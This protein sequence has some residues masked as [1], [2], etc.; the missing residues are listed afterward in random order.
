[1]NAV[2]SN[3]DVIV[4]GSGFGGSLMATILAKQ[5]MSVAIVD[6][7]VHPRF[8]IGESSTPSGNLILGD[9]ARR[10]DL[11]EL[12]PLTHFGSW[13]HTYPDLL[14]GC[15]RGFSYFWHGDPTGFH[16]SNEHQHELLVAANLSR[17]VADTQWYRPQVDQFFANN[18]RKHGVD[19][20]E[21]TKIQ[22]IE[23]PSTNLWVIR[24][25]SQGKPLTFEAPFL[26]DA[27]GKA[28]VL[29]RQLDLTDLTS[30][31]E[32][33]SSAIYGHFIG[34]PPFEETLQAQGARLSDYPFP[35]DDS[36]IH[37]LFRDGWSFQL[38]F[39]DG[40][41]SFG[42]I[43]VANDR[44]SLGLASETSLLHNRPSLTQVLGNS[45]L[46]PLPGRLYHIDR[47]Q[48]LWESAAGCDWAALPF[49]T[50]FIDALH[51]TG[52]AHNLSGIERLAEILLNA[53]GK[54]R[55]DALRQYSRQIVRELQLIDLLVAGCYA[56]LA[57]FRLF[58]AWSMLYFAA[59]TSYE[60][61]R[62]AHSSEEVSYL[63]AGDDSFDS[64]ISTHYQLLIRLVESNRL[65]DTAIENFRQQLKSAIAP[66]NHVGLFEPAISNMYTYTAAPS[67]SA[68]QP[69]PSRQRSQ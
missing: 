31:L 2:G 50:G 25:E 42:S 17:E 36:A 13:R 29:P 9:L 30:Q 39:D 40:L 4:I 37:H 38:R 34:V 66:Y 1:M 67:Q 24:A 62:C 27:S 46:A 28:G 47:M 57:D 3:Y 65:D 58:T 12:T 43:Q 22:S 68:R 20:L 7:G 23:H 16:A 64:I 19:L 44:H 33:K 69:R 54:A 61:A 56:G 59:A 6:H 5:G 10:Y 15:K 45:Q 51:S 18:S 11:P 35:V 55:E 49:T 14:C 60:K 32:T 26:I 21:E 41:T 8:A 52:I 48:R 53:S 63:L